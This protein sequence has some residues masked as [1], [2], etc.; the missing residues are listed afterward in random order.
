MAVGTATI[1]ETRKEKPQQ[2]YPGWGCGCK[3]GIGGEANLKMDPG[4]DQIILE[5]WAVRCSL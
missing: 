3:L 5:H 2:D 1:N 4:P